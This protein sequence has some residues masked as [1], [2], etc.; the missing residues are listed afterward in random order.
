M[1]GTSEL[2]SLD[3][4]PANDKDL[5]TEITTALRKQGV[6]GIVLVNE[7]DFQGFES[8]LNTAWQINDLVVQVIENPITNRSQQNLKYCGTAE[9]IGAKV[10]Q[11][12]GGVEYGHH[13]TF[14]L[15]KIEIGEDNNLLTSKVT[16]QCL[17]TTNLSSYVPPED[18]T[19][20]IPF[21]SQEWV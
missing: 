14:N 5:E 10:S 16:F 12:L 4:F 1:N 8:G 19:V 15:K 9:D 3:F 2:S 21:A 13:Q 11:V 18:P 17:V 20:R 6:C 7:A